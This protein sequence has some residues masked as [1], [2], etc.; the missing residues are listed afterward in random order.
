LTTPKSKDGSDRKTIEGYIGG[1]P[2]TQQK[3]VSS[4]VNLVREAA[5]RSSSSIKW[6]QP[7]FEENGPFC[8][9]RAYRN[10]VNLGFWRGVDISSGKGF[11]QSEGKKMAHAKIVVLKDIKKP[12]F[13]EWV[14]EA[15]RLNQLN[16][17]PTKKR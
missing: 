1:L 8:Y 7:V 12:L 13:Q 11:L 16:G 15:V 3:I 10:H 14:K 5:P 2:Q 17:D 9:I 6:A 4:L